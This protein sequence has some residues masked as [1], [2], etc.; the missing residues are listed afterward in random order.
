MIQQKVSL[1]S[2]KTTVAKDGYETEE[3]SEMRADTQKLLEEII[4]RFLKRSKKFPIEC[5]RLQ[6]CSLEKGKITSM[7]EHTHG[8]RA[9]HEVWFVDER[10][11]RGKHS[12]SYSEYFKLTPQNLEIY[13]QAKDLEHHIELLQNQKEEKLKELSDPV[14]LEEDFL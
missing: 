3:T 4:D 9:Y 7:T 6:D 2:Y 1:K 12:F 10:G 8:G 14:T 11:Q 13:E 5:I